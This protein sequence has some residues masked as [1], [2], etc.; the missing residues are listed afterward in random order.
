MAFDYM[1]T[2]HTMEIKVTS[3]LNYPDFMTRYNALD[4]ASEIRRCG[5][6]LYSLRVNPHKINGVDDKG[7]Y[8]LRYLSL[9]EHKSILDRIQADL[10]AESLT[11]TRLDLCCD[12]QI[13]Y[14]PTE[15]L[16]RFLVLML[17][18]QIEAHNRYMSVDPLTLETK[19]IRVETKKGYN[20][21]NYNGELQIEHYN[22]TLLDQS[23]WDYTVLNRLEFRSSGTEAGENYSV[24]EIIDR[25]KS[26]LQAVS[27]PVE[28]TQRMRTV[29]N[30][31]NQTLIERWKQLSFLMDA[32]TGKTFNDFVFFNLNHIFT[33][34]QMMNLF[35]LYGDT[36]QQAENRAKNI[37]RDRRRAFKG[38]LFTKKQ[39]SEEAESLIHSI[40]FFIHK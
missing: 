33:R 27:E 39:L 23:S 30:A 18:N 8:Y 17:A 1:T 25:W 26:R 38:Q 9:N 3:E 29:E 37:R 2:I 22:R 5:G 40:D 35:M 28:M 24:E 12:P 31:V 10:G 4:Y 19:T 6:G 14:A 21:K 16:L 34:R 13:D 20:G 36:E 11:V 7:L 32:P 15:K